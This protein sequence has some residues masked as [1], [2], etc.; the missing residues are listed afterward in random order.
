M[1]GATAVCVQ[2]RGLGRGT[3]AVSS[4][5]LL[6]A[7]QVVS[8]GGDQGAPALPDGV[9]LVKPLNGASIGL[10][11]V[12]HSGSDVNVVGEVAVRGCLA[13]AVDGGCQVVLCAAYA[14]DLARV[15]LR[16]AMEQA[17]R[18]GGGRKAKQKPRQVRTVRRDGRGPLDLAAAI[19]ALV[20]SGPGNSRPLA[21]RCA[22]GGPPPPPE[23][24]G[25]LEAVGYGAGTR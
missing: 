4:L 20:S 22:S 16:A 14:V 9:F 7:A 5:P 13:Q 11:Q 21:P 23:L 6:G 18:N 10:G 19:G 8:A 1:F 3:V 2:A 17:R 12:A 24:A 15:A 25:Y